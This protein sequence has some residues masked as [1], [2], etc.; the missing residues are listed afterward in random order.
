MSLAEF[1]L[2]WI[3]SSCTF[4]LVYAANTYTHTHTLTLAD[5]VT[6][7]VRAMRCSWL[8]ISIVCAHLAFVFIW[9]FSPG[10]VL[11]ERTNK[12]RWLA[13][14]VGCGAAGSAKKGARLGWLVRPLLQKLLSFSEP[15]RRLSR[16]MHGKCVRVSHNLYLYLNIICGYSLSG[17]PSRDISAR[18]AAAS[19]AQLPVCHALGLTTTKVK[20]FNMHIAQVNTFIVFYLWFYMRVVVQYFQSQLTFGWLSKWTRNCHTENKPH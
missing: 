3:P 9:R 10:R 11:I 13:R 2:I 4:L 7:I 16:P 5:T 20:A 12:W 6:V 19:A 15:W 18:L 8:C 1:W 14:R 17:R